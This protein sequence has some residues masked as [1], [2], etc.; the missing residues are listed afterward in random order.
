VKYLFWFILVLG[1]AATLHAAS[2]QHGQ[3][4]TGK[5]PIPGALVRATQGDKVVRAITDADGNYTMADMSDG[6]WTIQV[7][8]L[9][10]EPIR[11][12]VVVP[13]TGSGTESPVWDMKLLP[14]GEIHADAAPGFLSTSPALRLSQTRSAP[15]VN[16]SP[17]LNSAPARRPVTGDSIDRAADGLL[18]N[19]TSNNGASTPFALPSA[20]G[21][22][23]RGR[24]SLYTGTITL[25]GNNALYDARPYSLTGQDTPQPSY[26]RIQSGI[27]IGGPFQIPNLFHRG[28]F[29]VSYNRTQNRNATVQTAEMPTFAERNGDFSASSRTVVDPISGLPFDG[30]VIPQDRIS[31]QARALL[32]LYPL[33]NLI[34]SSRYNYQVPLVGVTHGD[35]FFA[36]LT[37]IAVSN[38]DRLSGSVSFSSTRTDSPNLFGFVDRG[39]NSTSIGSITWTHRFT[40][41][42]SANIRYQFSRNTAL[43]TP[44]FAYQQDVSGNAGITGNDPDPRNW[45]PPSLDF[46]GGIARLSD[47]Q[48][49]FNRNQASAISYTSNWTHRRHGFSYG[50]DYRKQQF[51]LFSQQDPRGGFSFT[52]AASGIDFA[53]FLL[54]IPTTSSIA[55]GNA[56]KYFRQSISD[57]FVMD[58]WRVK[59]SLTL[60]LGVRWEYESPIT[61]LYGRLVN[62]DI[63]PGFA[64]AVPVIAGSPDESLVHPDKRGVEPRIALAW[65]PR[66]TSSMVVRA[67]YGIYRDTSV[68]RSIADQMSQQA[69]LSKS[70]SVQNTPENPLTLANGFQGSPTVSATTFAIDPNFQVGNAQN[71]NLS[72]QQDLPSAMQLTATYLGIKG[73]HV[74]QRILPNTFPAGGVDPCSSCPTGYVYLMSSGNSSRHAGTIEV[75]RRQRNGFQGSVSYTFSKAIDDAGLGGTSIAQN[76]LDLRSERALSNFDQ[77]HLVTAQVQYTS[78]M[79]TKFG[80]FWDGWRGDV[81]KEWTL[82]TQLTAGSGLPLTPVIPAPVSGTGITGSLR[83]DVTGASL[84][85]NSSNRN[86]NLLAYAAPV[87]GQWG[88]AGRNSITGPGQFALNAS[89]VRTFHVAERVT[90]D[91]RVDAT[92]VLNHPT[93]PSWNTVV[94]SSQ[95]GL[96]VN[97]NAMRTIQPSIRV[98]F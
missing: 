23:R 83:P 47:A 72:I 13:P 51:N 86:L 79:L 63:G 60:N 4:R 96:P 34:G 56:D 84:Y 75:R 90:M 14:V 76:W 38:S 66:A 67:G 28:S 30:N 18:I 55:F 69:P 97:A 80:S 17:V 92:N 29:T 19:G 5:V 91:L 62:L 24:R 11:E 35:N 68:Y 45:G 93:F 58:D 88:N 54:S 39:D 57:V 37:N 41:R 22:S 43:L 46:A 85:E 95:Y 70:L 16:I 61:E 12:E 32:D 59:S 82:T 71:W 33:P 31:P 8:M 44:H 27:T 53:D 25:V 9:G 64:T 21:N 42:V 74:P 52:G 48:Y 36:G 40:A 1:I 2:E 73:T 49:S 6:T 81:L 15:A 98:R 65:R 77:R 20:I 94:T 7:E 3:V 78:G 10:F 26:N 87:P 89:L 50:A